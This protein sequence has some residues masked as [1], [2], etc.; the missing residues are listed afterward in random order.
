MHSR[1][2]LPYPRTSSCRAN[3]KKRPSRGRP[4]EKE[5]Y[6]CRICKFRLI[7][8]RFSSLNIFSSSNRHVRFKRIV[9]A[10][11]CEKSRIQVLKN[12]NLLGSMRHQWLKTPWLLLNVC[13]HLGFPTQTAQAFW[14]KTNDGANWLRKSRKVPSTSTHCL[15]LRKITKRPVYG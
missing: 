10:H 14:L 9:L 3:F 7:L 11:F 6:Y 15:A 2:N 13:W 12:N 4:P 8:A 5:R 1:G